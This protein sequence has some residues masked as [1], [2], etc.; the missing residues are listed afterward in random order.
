MHN[1]GNCSAAS[2][3]DSEQLDFDG[4]V[5]DNSVGQS[6]GATN[7]ESGGSLLPIKMDSNGQLLDGSISTSSLLNATV[8]NAYYIGVKDVI[9]TV[10]IKR[11]KAAFALE[12]SLTGSFTNTSQAGRTTNEDVDGE[13]ILRK[14]VPNN[15]R[16]SSSKDLLLVGCF[17][18]LV[19]YDA[20]SRSSLFTINTPTPVNAIA[21]TSTNNS[22]GNHLNQSTNE[23]CLFACGGPQR[24]YLLKLETNLKGDMSAEVTSERSIEDTVNCLVWGRL[25]GMSLVLIG[26]LEH[27]ISVFQLDT[28]DQNIQACR[29]N[30]TESAVVNCLLPINTVEDCCN[31]QSDQQQ[32]PE[33][34]TQITQHKPR[35][36]NAT[37]NDKYLPA[38]TNGDSQLTS[39][40]PTNSSQI[41]Q[42]NYFAFGLE[43]GLIGV[44]RLLVTSAPGSLLNQI[45]SPVKLTS[46]R[47]W[48]YRCKHVPMSMLLGDTNGDG[49][50]ELV[51]GF[52]SGRIEV[53]S[54]FTGQLLSVTR[55]FKRDHGLAGLAMLEDDDNENQEGERKLIACSTNGALIAFKATPLLQGST[56]RP[57]QGF[58]ASKS[59]SSDIQSLRESNSNWLYSSLQLANQQQ[60]VASSDLKTIEE[61]MRTDVFMAWPS[62]QVRDGSSSP[63]TDDLHI[64]SKSDETKPTKCDSMQN[65][66]L[67]QRV[68]ALYGQQLDLQKRACRIYQSHVQQH[69]P[70]G[71]HQ[72]M[73]THRVNVAHRWD[74]NLNAVSNEP[75]NSKPAISTH[76][77]SYARRSGCFVSLSPLLL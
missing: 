33:G 66:D 62:G 35:S 1:C 54:P 21:T 44:Y 73:Q 8:A 32:T 26:S 14:L 52:T 75:S 2:R 50:D 18:R 31:K 36:D 59:S 16:L 37:R 25:D 15:K 43:S 23:D 30:I 34:L 27:K 12:S 76:S 11:V 20:S 71:L 51:I 3:P 58:K 7:E 69:R 72:Q 65:L 10:A 60:Q 41:A 5:N 56:R 61:E 49:L 22:S 77:S 28:F 39:I 4:S 68:N 6:D 47:V 40:R 53:R 48:R 9:K 24:L 17:T 57:L 13:G 19:I 46:E 74:F 64:E 55:A 63:S 38:V 42:M 45:N 29:L 67:L 70:V